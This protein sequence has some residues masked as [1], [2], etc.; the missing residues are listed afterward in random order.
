MMR[1][2]PVFSAALVA[3]VCFLSPVSAGEPDGDAILRAMCDKL[4]AAQSLRFE[5]VREIDAALLEGRDAASKATVSV[6]MQRPARIAA[7]SVSR[8]GTRRFVADGAN[9]SVLDAK[10]N[11]YAVIP[12][13]VGIDGLVQRL[14]T[15]YG[16]TPPLAEFA[17]SDVYAQFR[18]E[19]RTV[20]YA[21]KG[22]LGGFLGLGGTLCHRLSLSGP[23]ADAELWVGVADNLPK[24]LVATFRTEGQPQVRIRFRSW[25]IDPA[26]A[27]ETFTFNPPAGSARI[28][29]WTTRQM[30]AAA[31]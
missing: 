13:A 21:G 10:E 30:E 20:S 7:T 17:V 28:E 22:R 4:S 19:A 23:Q 26:V 11:L 8:C 9:L 24:R 3:S 15:H 14:D 1:S 27:P 5:A 6:V 25:E 12:M 29:M 16:F 2:L 18:R 31:R